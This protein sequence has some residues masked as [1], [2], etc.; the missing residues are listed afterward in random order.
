MPL[1]FDMKFIWRDQ[2]T[3]RNGDDCAFS[4]ETSIKVKLFNEIPSEIR[5]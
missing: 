4:L 1:S 2:K 5:R 3:R